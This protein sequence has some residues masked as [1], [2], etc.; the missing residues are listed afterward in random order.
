MIIKMKFLFTILS[1]LMV[2]EAVG[3]T[4]KNSGKLQLLILTGSGNH[5][6]KATTLQLKNNY[7]ESNRFEVFVTTSPDT[8]TYQDFKRFDVV[9]SNWNSWPE[10][11]DKWT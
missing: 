10:N 5:D 7:I 11:N 1:F 3:S 2:V 6:W 9:V 8:L 4:K